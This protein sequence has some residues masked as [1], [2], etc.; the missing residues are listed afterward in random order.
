MAR[1]AALLIPATVAACAA[2]SETGPTGVTTDPFADAGG[3]ISTGPADGGSASSSGGTGSG[4]SSGSGSG[5]S[6]G[7]ETSDA[8]SSDSASSETSDTRDASDAS[9]SDE[10]S[11]APDATDA[12]VSDGDAASDGA[13]TTSCPISITE[14]SY[15][16]SYDG[17]ITYVNTGTG[18]ETNPT[19]KFTLPSSAT[20]D[21]SGCTGSTGLDNQTVPSGI[22]AL[23]CSQ[24][25]TTVVYVFTGTVPANAKMEIYYTTNLAS[26]AAA[27]AVTVTATSCP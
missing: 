12:N 4:G 3:G 22:T 9:S 8:N 26:E 21:K 1:F 7:G 10:D 14:D 2:G 18:S 15:D 13:T 25:G 19:V 17:Y 6:T 27:T 23:S 24:T 16:T 11:S 5:G 20:L